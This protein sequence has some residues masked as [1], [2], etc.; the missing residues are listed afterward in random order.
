M[1]PGNY[2]RF[3]FNFMRIKYISPKICINF[4][5]ILFQS[6]LYNLQIS[7]ET[8]LQ[9]FLKLPQRT[10]KYPRFPPHYS[11]QISPET[12]L[13]VFPKSSQSI[14]PNIQARIPLKIHENSSR[15]TS[16]KFS[17]YSSR[18]CSRISSI[19]FSDEFSPYFSEKTFR[20]QTSS[21]RISQTNACYQGLLSY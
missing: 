19:I 1:A 18:N 13:Q 21:L 5:Q 2:P 11:F 17:E 14:S 6:F 10:N 15:G 9:V 12:P 4:L 3:Y 8:S 7:T 20:N 16:R